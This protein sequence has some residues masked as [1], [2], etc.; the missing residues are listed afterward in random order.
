[1]YFGLRTQ[2]WEVSYCL[3]SHG[4]LCPG[5]KLF[6]P[7]SGIRMLGLKFQSLPYYPWNLGQV[8]RPLYT[9]VS[10]FIK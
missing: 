1:M 3:F 2:W 10:S 6:S 5:I 8:P 4:L 7:S 9:S